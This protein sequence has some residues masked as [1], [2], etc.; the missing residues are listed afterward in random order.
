MK[1]RLVQADE[2]ISFKNLKYS[3]LLFNIDVSLVLD[4]NQA[5]NTN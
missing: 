1:S 5:G 4:I 3:W 2:H